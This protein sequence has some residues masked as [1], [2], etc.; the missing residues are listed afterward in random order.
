MFIT[1]S[2]YATIVAC[3]LASSFAFAG[4]IKGKV[5]FKGTKPNPTEIKMIADPNCIK[6]HAGKK[7]TSDQVVVNTNNTLRHVFVYVKKGLEGKKFPKPTQ[8]V[9]IDQQGCTY[10]PHLFGMMASQ[11]LEIINSDPTM[12]NIHALPKNSKQFNIAQPRK[13]MKRVQ[14][15]DK[16]EV[17][18]KIKCDVHPWMAAYVGVL[19]HPFYAVTDDQGN[20]E[21]KNLPA[22]D[23]E[24]EAWHE[25][26]GSQTMKV[27]VGAADT[28]TV[29]FSSDKFVASK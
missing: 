12:H 20:Y 9:T 17:M 25:K 27:S 28:K 21:I 26:Y 24:I 11:P 8:K 29:D 2:I 18:V 13:G 23:Y 4:N 22:G 10:H 3:C 19:D 14:T 6:I 1:S 5:D 16:P 15:F 7:V